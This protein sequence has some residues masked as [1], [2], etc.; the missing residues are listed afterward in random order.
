ML[1]C[2]PEQSGQGTDA[3]EFGSVPLPVMD[4]SFDRIASHKPEWKLN[5]KRSR[6][7]G[8]STRAAAFRCHNQAEIGDVAQDQTA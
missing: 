8:V 5:R 3:G 2:G 4:G 1:F 6:P 7:L